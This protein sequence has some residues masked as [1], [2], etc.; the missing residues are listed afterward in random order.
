MFISQGKTIHTK[1][2][3]KTLLQR[4]TGIHIERDGKGQDDKQEKETEKRKREVKAVNM[5]EQGIQS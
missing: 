4:P 1:V 5:R 2:T 3:L